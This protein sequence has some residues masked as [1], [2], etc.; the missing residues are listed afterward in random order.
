MLLY[1]GKAAGIWNRK[2]LHGRVS[3]IPQKSQLL[4]VQKLFRGLDIQPTLPQNLEGSAQ[5]QWLSPTHASGHPS[6]PFIKPSDISFHLLLIPFVIK[7]CALPAPSMQVSGCME[8]LATNLSSSS[9]SLHM[10]F[11]L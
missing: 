5:N 1:L 4:Q 6:L 10:T 2:V 8:F 11:F 9:G 7:P 3:G